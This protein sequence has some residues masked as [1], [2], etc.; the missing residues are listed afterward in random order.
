MRWLQRLQY[1]WYYV[2]VKKLPD[3]QRGDLV[4]VENQWILKDYV[5]YY[6]PATVIA[7]DEP[8]FNAAETKMKVQ[9]TTAAARKV[10]LYR[11]EPGGAKSG[12]Q[13]IRAY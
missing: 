13:L 2:E 10:Y 6:T 7:T 3:L 12:W 4:I 1:D 8:D 5:R 9:E 11:N